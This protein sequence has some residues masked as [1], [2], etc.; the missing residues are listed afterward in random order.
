MALGG[1]KVLKRQTRGGVEKDLRR[2]SCPATGGRHSSTIDF[3]NSLKDNAS[4][5]RSMRRSVTHFA[6]FVFSLLFQ[7]AL[8]HEVE[9]QFARI[10]PTK[11]NPRLHPL[12]PGIFWSRMTRK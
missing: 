3:A 7:Q 12:R 8:G 4:R 11:T 6:V 2:V 5:L 10:I 9:F 1:L